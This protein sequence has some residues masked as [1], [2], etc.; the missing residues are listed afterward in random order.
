M[1]LKNTK[2]MHNTL[3]IIG[4]IVGQ[5]KKSVITHSLTHS[6]VKYNLLKYNSI[7]PYGHLVPM[8]GFLYMPILNY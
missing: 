6:L 8:R 2:I 7:L 3:K 4:Q 1:S 5:F